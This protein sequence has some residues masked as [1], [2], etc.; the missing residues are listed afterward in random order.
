MLGGQ[1]G[2]GYVDPEEVKQDV[3]SQSESQSV[4]QVVGSEPQAQPNQPQAENQSLQGFGNTENL[5]VE[6]DNVEDEAAPQVVQEGES[7]EAEGEQYW[8]DEP[9]AENE[10]DEDE[11][12]EEEEKIDTDV[13]KNG[14]QHYSRNCQLYCFQCDKFFTCRFCHDEFWDSNFKEVEKHHYIDRFTVRQVK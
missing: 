8:V 7:L 12:D 10:E 6:A 4:Q 13:T 9:E 5:P 14:C 3:Q 2:E 1:I 11:D